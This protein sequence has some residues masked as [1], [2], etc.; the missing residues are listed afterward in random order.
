MCFSLFEF[1]SEQEVAQWHPL[2]DTV[3]GGIS[4]CGICWNSGSTATFMGKVSLD[5]NG[6]FASI[7]SLVSGVGEGQGIALRVKGDGR[8]KFKLR[9]DPFV[10]GI[11]Y[12]QP[13]RSMNED[14]QEIELPFVDFKPY[15]RGLPIPDAPKLE[16]GKIQQ[17]G[18]LIGDKQQGTFALEID[19][20]RCY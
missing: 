12:V 13:F 16:P 5:N 18:I 2:N 19:W 3:M 15:F 10:E 17:I 9:T 1:S 20:I 6:G 7:R 11:H 4:T 8:F 14:W